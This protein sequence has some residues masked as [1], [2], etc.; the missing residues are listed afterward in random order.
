MSEARYGSWKSPITSDLIV[1]STVGLGAIQLDGEDVYWLEGRPREGGRQVLVRRT[2][3]GTMRDVTPAPFNV[4]TRVHEYGGGAYTVSDGSVIFAN[5]SDQH[6]YTIESDGEPRPLTHLDGM[7]YADGCVDRTR[8]RLYCVRE[9]HTGEGEAVNTIVAVDLDSGSEQVLVSGSDFY[10]NPRL[11]PDGRRL[12]WLSWDH[13]NMPW[14]ATQLWVANVADDGNALIGPRRV[15][16]PERESILQPEWA[17][18]GDLLFVS[19]RSGWWNLYRASGGGVEPLIEMEAEFGVPAWTFDTRT[20]APLRD[21]HIAAT[22]SRD[23]ISRLAIIEPQGHLI[24]PID[25]PLSAFGGI[26]AADS[27]EQVFFVG[28]SATMPAAVYSLDLGNHGLTPLAWSTDL[29]IDGG[30]I[31]LPEPVEFP[32]EGGLPAHALFYAPENKDF[33]ALVGEKPP[34]IVMSHGGPTAAAGGALSLGRQFWT[35]RGFAVLDVNYGGSTGYGRAYR[36][37]L[38]GRWGIVDVDDCVNGA[39]YLAGQGRVDGDRMAITGGSAGGYTTL[40]ALTFRDVFKAGASHYGIG[41]L[42]ALARDTHKFESRYLDGLVGP[43]PERRDIYLERSP[44]DH[45]DQLSRPVIF[46]QGLEDQI[47][48]PNQAEAMVDALRRKGVPVAYLAFEGEQHGFRMAENIKRSLDAELYFYGRIFGF[49]PADAIEP[50][51]IE[52]L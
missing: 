42:E 37:R 7:R 21:G 17:A 39:L 28:A 41:D 43:Y 49:E 32:T 19:D 16:G 47:V 35:S 40:A 23:G 4:R 3:D 14:D 1:S 18:N 31:S 46:F 27:G 22:F 20:Y 51:A 34:L 10:A 44:I 6:L 25:L 15:P 29:R 8:R 24:D 5:F 45:V 33:S 50:V 30:Y 13:P 11:T 12:C 48:P 9:D 36:E 26:R 2:P 38:N 52:N